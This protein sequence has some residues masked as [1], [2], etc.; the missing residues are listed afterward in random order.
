MDQML[1]QRL[2]GAIILV[3]LAVIFI[4]LILEGP[5]D[6][7][8]PRSQDMPPPP[9]ID[10]QAEV[11]LPIPTGTPDTATSPA[12]APTVDNPAAEP[13]SPAEPAVKPAML[14]D[15]P[16][17]QPVAADKPPPAAAAPPAAPA[18][19]ATDD[20][21]VIQVGSF[22]QQL[23]AQGLRDRLRKA[24]YTVF[25][26]DVKAGTA[27]TWRVLVGPLDERGKAEQLRDKLSREQHLKGIVIQHPG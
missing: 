14:P 16:I 9:R 4:P 18:T 20:A 26:R 11:E 24:G 27:H 15:G 12:D 1:K 17:Q 22:S 3:S 13:E 19:S 23:N 25:L 2:V 8:S 21:W 10:Y 5:D 6:E 7:R